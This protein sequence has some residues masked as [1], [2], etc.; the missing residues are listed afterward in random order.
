M[1]AQAIDQTK[2][3]RQLSGGGWKME[4]G[5]G[6]GTRI[7]VPWPLGEPERNCALDL[8]DKYGPPRTDNTV[9]RPER[10]LV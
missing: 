10:F 7:S 5:A 6:Q 3:S 8:S 2:Q 9:I 1:C 4:S